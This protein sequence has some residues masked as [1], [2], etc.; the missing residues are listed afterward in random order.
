MAEAVASSQ[1]TS[2]KT[3]L[4]KSGEVNP[5]V[6]YFGSRRL[7]QPSPDVVLKCLANALNKRGGFAQNENLYNPLRKAK[8]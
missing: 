4:L 7:E 1:N 5:I 8:P 2:P 6:P 3:S